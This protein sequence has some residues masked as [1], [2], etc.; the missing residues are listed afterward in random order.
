MKNYS[1]SDKI[2]VLLAW[3]LVHVVIGIVSMY[4]SNVCTNT[5]AFISVFIAF[6][7]AHYKWSSKM[8]AEAKKVFGFGE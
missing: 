4:V 1:T 5:A 6:T 3:V 7:F 8:I 2:A